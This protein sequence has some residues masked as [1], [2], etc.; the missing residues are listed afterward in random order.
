VTQAYYLDAD[1]IRWVNMQAD[2]AGRSRSWIVEQALSRY[3]KGVE[4]AQ[5]GLR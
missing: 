2:A 5:R 1:L 4:E 3:R